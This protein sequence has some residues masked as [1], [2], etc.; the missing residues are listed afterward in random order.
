[1]R[2][3][4]WQRLMPVFPGLVSSQFYYKKVQHVES[5]FAILETGAIE[6]FGLKSENWTFLEPRDAH[7][8]KIH[9]RY[10]LCVFVKLPR[11]WS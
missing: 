8:V 9:S 4:L 2:G 6:S 5:R 7:R 10:G 3:L 11:R 1:M